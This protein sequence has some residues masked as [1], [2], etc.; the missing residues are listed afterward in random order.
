MCTARQMESEPSTGPSS[1]AESRP[2]ESS[3]SGPSSSGPAAV[4]SSKSERD[5]SQEPGQEVIVSPL[6]KLRSPK[7]SDFARRHKIA[8]NPPCGKCRSCGTSDTDVKTI[9]PEK[10]VRDYPNEPLTVSNNKL[11]CRG[12]REELCLKSSSLK[13]HFSSRK[14]LDGKKEARE[15]DIAQA[16]KKYNSECHPRG[17]TLPESQQVYRVKLFRTFLQAGVPLSKLSIFRDLLEEIGFRLSDRRFILDLIPFILNEEEACL[18]Q[19]LV[20]KQVGVIIDGTTWL[21]ETMALILRFVSESWMLEQRLV[22][23]Q[24]LSKSTTGKEIARE[25]IHVLSANYAIGPD[26]LIRAAVNG[27]VMRTMTVVYPKLLDI[28]CFSHTIDRVGEHFK[29][30]VLSKCFTTWIMLFSHS[31][32]AKLLWKEQTGRSVTS[33]SI[34]RWWSR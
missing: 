9:R 25:L 15:Q 34:T 18:K 20:G 3:T 21:G 31:P 26:Q 11:F 7:I 16:L 22:R 6:S 2:A 29:T 33:Y 1:S 30:L 14:H 13:T 4:D 8:V 28:G 12:C 32:K 19:E 10:P 23:I 27:V 24:L 5:D 17:E